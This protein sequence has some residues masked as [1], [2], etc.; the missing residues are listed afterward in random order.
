MKVVVGFD[1]AV[2]GWMQRLAKTSASQANDRWNF[3]SEKLGKL[4]GNCI[5][6]SGPV[7]LLLKSTMLSVVS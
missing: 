2:S 7:L 1:D 3:T 4:L 5:F 6:M